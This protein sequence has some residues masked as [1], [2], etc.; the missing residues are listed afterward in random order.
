MRRVYRWFDSFSSDEVVFL[1]GT[2][3]SN[4]FLINLDMEMEVSD[5]LL[6]P[7]INR[8]RNDPALNTDGPSPSTTQVVFSVTETPSTFTA[9]VKSDPMT[10]DGSVRR[11]AQRRRSVMNIWMATVSRRLGQRRH[12]YQ[13]L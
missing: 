7:I 10:N 4:I 8:K 11:V 13:R 2:E 6:T 3:P 5:R 12:M 9:D 1:T